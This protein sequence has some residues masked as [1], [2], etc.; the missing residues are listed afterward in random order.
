MAAKRKY[1]HATKKIAEAIDDGNHT[2]AAIYMEK[3]VNE[4]VGK[5]IKS[6][7]DRLDNIEKGNR[8]GFDKLAKAINN[9]ASA[10]KQ[11][12]S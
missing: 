6:T 9:L 4:E 10:L 11:K 2:A 7:N 3:I 1:M 12:S 5:Q 8:E